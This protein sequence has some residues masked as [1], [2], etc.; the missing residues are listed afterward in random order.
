MTEVQ[1]AYLKAVTMLIS[2]EIREKTVFTDTRVSWGGSNHSIGTF[3]AFLET[4]KEEQ[5]DGSFKK[6]VKNGKIHIFQ[7]FTS[8]SMQTSLRTSLTEVMLQAREEF[9]THTQ[10]TSFSFTLY[11]RPPEHQ[12]DF[13]SK[14]ISYLTRDA[15]KE[16]VYQHL[17]CAAYG[18][19]ILPEHR[20]FQKHEELSLAEGIEKEG[21]FY[22][23]ACLSSTFRTLTT[24]QYSFVIHRVITEKRYTFTTLCNEGHNKIILARLSRDEKS[25]WVEIARDHNRHHWIQSIQWSSEEFS[26]LT[27]REFS[28]QIAEAYLRI[29]PNER[30]GVLSLITEA[31]IHESE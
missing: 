11:D 5:P 4:R 7:P 13:D 19:R 6:R 10:A 31:G 2:K 27:L 1:I 14:D 26:S 23:A 24:R 8:V 25:I 30:V 12:K 22:I 28:S 3:R 18:T 16:A 21:I 20:F 17:I 9:G 29:H 15:I